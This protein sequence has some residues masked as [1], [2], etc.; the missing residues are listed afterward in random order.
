MGYP[1]NYATTAELY[2]LIKNKSSFTLQTQIDDLDTTIIVNESLENIET[3]VYV[4]HN[5]CN[6]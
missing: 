1:T 5:R 4:R 6:R 2:N 3:P